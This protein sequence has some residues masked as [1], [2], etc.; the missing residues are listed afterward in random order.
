VVEVSEEVE[1][2]ALFVVVAVDIVVVAED[3]VAVGSVEALLESRLVSHQTREW[4][5]RQ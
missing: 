3:Y 4:Q 1:G 5:L 2:A